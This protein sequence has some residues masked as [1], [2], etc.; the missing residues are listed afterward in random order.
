MCGFGSICCFFFCLSWVFCVQDISIVNSDIQAKGVGDG[1]NRKAEVVEEMRQLACSRAAG[2]VGSGVRWRFL[3][4]ALF[5][6]RQ[7]VWFALYTLI[8][9]YRRVYQLIPFVEEPYF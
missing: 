1:M 4:L 7:G 6:S 5:L 9:P 8:V 2:F 3:S